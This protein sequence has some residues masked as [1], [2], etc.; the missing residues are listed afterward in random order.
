MTPGPEAGRYTPQMLPP[1]RCYCSGHALLLFFF[2]AQLTVN[3]ARRVGYFRWV[4][5]C[6]RHRGFHHPATA[7]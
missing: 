2:V 5:S 1:S 7:G 6:R 3:S 4:G